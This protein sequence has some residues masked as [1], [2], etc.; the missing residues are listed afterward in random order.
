MKKRKNNDESVIFDDQKGQE[1]AKNTQ[2]N[3]ALVSSSGEPPKGGRGW[4]TESP[5]DNIRSCPK[6]STKVEY[7]SWE[8]QFLAK[9][10]FTFIRCNAFET[11]PLLM[12][13][14]MSEDGKWREQPT[15]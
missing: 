4:R 14:F 9:T 1:I 3:S 2:A 12:S 15:D 5:L 13:G 11:A 10:I 8:G 6:L 7:K